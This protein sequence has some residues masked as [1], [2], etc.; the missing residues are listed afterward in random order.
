MG[1]NVF[2]ALHSDFAVE[3]IHSSPSGECEPGPTD[4]KKALFHF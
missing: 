1:K 4:D 3:S 2:G